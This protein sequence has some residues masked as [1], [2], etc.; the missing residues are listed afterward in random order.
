[1]QSDDHTWDV[2]NY[3]YC[4]YKHNSKIQKFCRNKYNLTGLCNKSSCPLANSQYATVREENGRCYLYMKVVERSHFPKRLWERIE[5]PRN[6]SEAIKVIDENLIYWSNFIRQKCKARLVR[7]HQCLIRMRKMAMKP[8]QKIIPLARKIERREKLR[9]GKALIAARL[10]N[11]IEKELLSRLKEGVYGD[12]Y[13]FNQKAFESV[14]NQ[15]EEVEV[16]EE[17]DRSE[18][19]RQFVEDFVESDEEGDEDIEDGGYTFDADSETSEEESDDDEEVPGPDDDEEEGDE[20]MEEI[21]QP[22][23]KVRFA[24]PPKKSK[25][26][27]K[28][29]GPRVEIEYE[30]VPASRKKLTR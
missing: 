17:T 24:A 20:D 21:Q 2:L 15:Q 11:A 18:L 13:N 8:H 1:M 19:Q 4:S 29:R 26:A 9:E 14:L 28:R 27:K 30:E 10:D 23:K 5:L 3:G 7:L 16:E 22:K 6:M 12:I 25:P